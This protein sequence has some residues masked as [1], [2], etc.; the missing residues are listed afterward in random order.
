M[1]YKE[2]TMN[3]KDMVVGSLISYI[4]SNIL[5]YII[6]LIIDETFMNQI[7]NIPFYIYGLIFTPFIFWI[8]RKI[9]RS[10][11]NEGIVDHISF[12]ET[13]KTIAK[14][15]YNKMIWIIEKDIQPPNRIHINE[16]PLCPKCGT[17]LYF[18]EHDLW[19]SYDCANPSCFFIKR[20]WESNDKMRTKIKMIYKHEK[21]KK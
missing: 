6:S 14:I 8:L 19:Y 7:I 9:I 13:Y 3:I 5:S 20:T 10:K 15:E 21:Q 11:M 17:E 1:N 4:I 12:G 18:L 16:T 2:K